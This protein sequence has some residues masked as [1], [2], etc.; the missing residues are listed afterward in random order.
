MA[1]RLVP[2]N[3]SYKKFLK[4][5]GITQVALWERIASD[6]WRIWK[7]VPVQEGNALTGL[8]AGKHNDP[9]SYSAK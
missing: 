2:E 4:V 7:L 8:D 1:Q 3:A 5:T 6:P 9:P